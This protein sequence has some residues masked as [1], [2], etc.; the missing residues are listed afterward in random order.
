M[1]KKNIEECLRGNK[2]HGDDFNLDQIKEWYEDEKNGYFDL[3]GASKK[4]NYY[5]SYHALNKLHAYKHL[6]NKSFQNVL[7]IG[8]AYGDELI[9]IINQIDNITILEPGTGFHQK[10]LE[11]KEI[12]YIEPNESG[13]MPFND[14]SFDLITCY[15]VLHH[16]PNI[17]F[18]MQE[19]QR[20]LKPGGYFLL[21]EPFVSMGDWRKPRLGLTK[22][23]RGIP[24]KIMDNIIK[25]S[26]FHIVR[27]KQCINIFSS[28]LIQFGK[29]Q[30]FSNHFLTLFDSLLSSLFNWNK[31]YFRDK[32]IKKFGN[33]S[34]FYILQK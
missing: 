18:V 23:E 34:V 33:S 2:L 27:K 31:I 10:K 32:T 14:N 28:A 24:L 4:E 3:S 26:P 5:Y 7:S 12:K 6:K 19:I 8:G 25:N 20:V 15:G 22:R 13:K 29:I 1:Q 21:R 17:S 9:P 30:V 16:I 11:G